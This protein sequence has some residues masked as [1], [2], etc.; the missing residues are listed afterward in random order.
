MPGGMEKHIY[1]LTQE[2]RK[3]YVVDVVFNEGESETLGDY[4]I[5]WFRYS[6]VKP[7]FVGVFLF[8]INVLFFLLLRKSRYD[9]VHIHGD[10]SSLILS[11]VVKRLVKS[12]VLIFSIH[13]KLQNSICYKNLLKYFLRPV[14]HIF[15]TGFETGTELQTMVG[16]KVTI[17]PSG[18]NHIYFEEC[19]TTCKD[20][21]VI[22]VANINAKKN[23]EFIVDIAAVNQH[24]SFVVVG[25]GGRRGYIESKIRDAQLQNIR[26][27]GNRN[28]LEIRTLLDRSSLFLLT[29]VEEGTPTA[30]LEAMTRGLPVVSSLVGGIEHILT[31]GENGFVISAFDVMDYSEKINKI[32]NDSR[33]YSYMQMHNI[34]KSREF[35]WERVAQKITQ[36]IGNKLR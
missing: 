4:R 15:A 36:V 21:D 9:V 28:A 34:N 7:A 1:F 6:K 30:V 23:I 20:I 31:D 8:Y 10:W 19:T 25:D 24:L 17:Q 5:G 26:L 35:K 22:T 32:L 16:N 12:K 14:N 29:S 11:S 33:I 27:L 13:G 3:Q 18:V 2:Q